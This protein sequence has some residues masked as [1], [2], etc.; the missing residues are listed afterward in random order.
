MEQ[1]LPRS[2]RGR[3]RRAAIL[4]AAGLLVGRRGYDGVTLRD[5]A[6]AAGTTHPLL[7]HYFRTKDELLLAV[8][9][10]WRERAED[11]GFG[12][13][14]DLDTVPERVVRL[15]EQNAA[16]PGYIALFT[17]LSSAASA[18]DHPLHDHFTERYR[19]VL[20]GL[21]RYFRHAEATGG[22]VPGVD[23]DAAA[24]SIVALQDGA[25]VQ[26]LYA[27]DE[28]D[29]PGLLRGAFGRLLVDQPG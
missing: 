25:Q 7:L 28:V 19:T 14:D 24:Q 4:D 6:T 20:E 21:R 13:D 16:T 10:T 15:A 3:A 8:V 26:W 27:P 22:L 18:P 11:L 23:P 17:T 5:I 12:R 9:D 2:A 1:G 29:V